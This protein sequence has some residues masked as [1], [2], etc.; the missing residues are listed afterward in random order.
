MTFADFNPPP[1]V[2]GF[3]VVAGRAQG[4]QKLMVVAGRLPDGDVG[5]VHVHEGDEVLRVVSGEIVVACGDER[6]TCHAGRGT[7]RD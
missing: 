3:D 2:A 6:R 4:L 7:N 5:P 1:G